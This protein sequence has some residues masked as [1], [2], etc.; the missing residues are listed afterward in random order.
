L[1]QWHDIT[2]LEGDRKQDDEVF[3][4][5]DRNPNL[6]PDDFLPDIEPRSAI[7]GLQRPSRMDF[8]RDGIENNLIGQ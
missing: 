5:Y 1:H 4:E 7:Q 3:V 8:V 2:I 6:I